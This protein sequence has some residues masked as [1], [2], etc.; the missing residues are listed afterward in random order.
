MALNKKE[1]AW[2]GQ[3]YY[4]PNRRGLQTEVMKKLGYTNHNTLYQKFYQF[5]RWMDK[6]NLKKYDR[7]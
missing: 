5:H 1:K 3:L 4:E 2:L 7:S 6:K